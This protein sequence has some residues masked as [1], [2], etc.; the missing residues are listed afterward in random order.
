MVESF[1]SL[2]YA[3][4]TPKPDAAQVKFFGRICAKRRS[5]TREIRGFLLQRKEPPLFEAKTN[6]KRGFPAISQFVHMFKNP[7]FRARKPGFPCKV[8]AKNA[9][10]VFPVYGSA[11]CTKISLAYFLPACYN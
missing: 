10:S 2:E 4:C 1:L 3:Y 7:L 6:K 5:A 9:P 8:E 11:D